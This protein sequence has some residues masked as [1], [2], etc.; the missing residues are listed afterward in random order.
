VRAGVPVPVHRLALEGRWFRPALLADVLEIEGFTA[1]HIA[2]R[3]RRA[4]ANHHPQR[5]HA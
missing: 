4:M 2:A 5:G 3:V 1:A